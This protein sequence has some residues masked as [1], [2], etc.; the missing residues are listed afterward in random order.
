MA[1]QTDWL[2]RIVDDPGAEAPRLDYAAWLDDCGDPRG[3]FIRV[4]CAL[5]R[6][7]PDDPPIRTFDEHVIVPEPWQLRDPE[8]LPFFGDPHWAPRLPHVA[9]YTT[10]RRA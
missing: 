8:Q 5:A 4:Q 6:R 3:E 9:A 7:L 1:K 10:H 2:A